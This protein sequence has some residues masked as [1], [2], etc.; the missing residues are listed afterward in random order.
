MRKTIAI[1][2]YAIVAVNMAIIARPYLNTPEPLTFEVALPQAAEVMPAEMVH[3]GTFK[4]ELPWNALK[5]RA[6]TT[7]YTGTIVSYGTGTVGASALVE[8]Y[9]PRGESTFYYSKVER[10]PHWPYG[11]KIGRVERNL[12]RFTAYPEITW[13]ILW[14]NLVMGV[15]FCGAIGFVVYPWKNHW[16][17]RGK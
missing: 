9:L 13:V 4:L 16:L 15:L 7:R 12:N 17:E 11:F 6:D 1:A 2:F 10:D 8:A 5:A 3:P 14:G